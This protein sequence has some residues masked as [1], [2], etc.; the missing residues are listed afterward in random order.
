MTHRMIRSLVVALMF[1]GTCAA[2]PLGDGGSIDAS[3][4]RATNLGCEYLHDPL[5]IDA[6]QPRLSWQLQSSQRG[7]K[8]TAYRVLVA[9]DEKL[10]VADRADLWDT[11]KV[12]SDQSVHV[13]YAGKPLDSRRRCYWKVRVWDKDGRLSPFSDIAMWEM[14]LLDDADWQAQWINDGKTDPNNDEDF[15]KDDPAPLFRKTFDL[16]KKVMKARLYITGLG[17]Y[18]ARLNGSRIGDHAL[19]PT[20]TAYSKRVFYSTYDVTEQ[21]QDGANCLAVMLGNGW[22]NPLPLRMWGH[23]NLRQ[24]LTVGRPRFIAQLEIELADGTRQTI[25]TDEHWKVTEGP[26]R[27]NSIYLGEVYDARE[28]VPNWDRPDGDDTNWGQAVMAKGPIGALLAQPLPPIR[29]TTTLKPVKITEPKEGTYLFDMGQNFAG[30]VKLALDVPK[31][32]KVQL[33]YGELLHEDGMLNPMTSVCGQI[34][35]TRQDADG[36]P[37]S[38]GGPGAPAIAWQGDT[39]IAKGGGPEVYTPRFTFHAFRYV[40]V[41]G[42]PAPPSLE[43]MTGLR[44]N[45]DVDSVGEFTCS[46]DLFNRIQTVCRW[47]FLSNIFGVQSDCP[48]RERFGYG[49][50]LVTTCDTFMLNFDMARF[51]AKAATDW[52]DSAL[53]DGMLTDTAPFVGIQY[54]GVAWA[55]AHPLLQQQLYRY[56]GDKRLIQA[57]YETSKRWFD[58]V[59]QKYPDHI[60][61]DGLSDHEALVG[62]PAAE[63][64]TPLYCESARILSQLACCLGRDQEAKDYANRAEAIRQTYY[65]KF[66]KDNNGRVGPGTQASQAFALQ[67]QMFDEGQSK[68]SDAALEYLIDDL[69]N[70]NKGHLTTGIFGTRYMLEVLSRNG[71]ASLVYDLVNSRECPGWGYMLDNG[72]TTL[73]EHW[74]FS[75]NTYSHNHP[76][77]GSVSQW[78]FNWLGGIQPDHE[79]VG[80]DRIVICPQVVGDLKWVRCAYD[81]IRG[82]IVSHWR[83]EGQTLYLDVTIP[84][85]TT[86]TVVLPTKDLTAV[87]ESDMPIFDV[88]GVHLGSQGGNNVVLEIESGHYTFAVLDIMDSTPTK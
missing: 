70:R 57:Q 43:M 78:F 49:G 88:P 28:E 62:A 76:M 54:C 44:L 39:Y 83:R 34:K 45:T 81:S 66:V 77:F 17:Y 64:V 56:Y 11:G 74:A 86:A 79:A 67:L 6:V 7:Q 5:G 51:Y 68:E 9:S 26:L 1:V 87:T 63:M 69:V 22:Y 13:T 75:D 46:N 37:V 85:N 60:V 3:D 41:T 36:K 14:G 31:G 4:M 84:P 55:M 2:G 8:Q 24:H 72:A 35:G 73:W 12:I 10:L 38:V 42:L 33:R 29:V 52:Q 15:Y 59:V 65:D 48:H 50:D 23:L 61:G 47:T 16:S 27:R 82:P 19:D 58:L 32:T 18:E 21:L 20:W 30:W 40:E 25:T 80:F 53:A 71:H